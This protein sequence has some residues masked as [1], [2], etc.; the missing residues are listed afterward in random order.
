M[1][2]PLRSLTGPEIVGLAA[3]VIGSFCVTLVAVAGIVAPNVRSA[4][5]TAAEAQLKRDMISA[6]FSADEIERVVRATAVESWAQV[7]ARAGCRPGVGHR[8]GFR[9]QQQQQSQA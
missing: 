8:H 1:D 7:A 3:I 9:S 6:G 5:Q 4:K 2:E